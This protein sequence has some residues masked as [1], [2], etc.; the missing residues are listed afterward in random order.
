MTMI[1][2]ITGT[3]IHI[4][5][6]ALVIEAHGI[7]YR[8]FVPQ[9]VVG[10]ACAH[11]T[12]SLWTSFVVR[13]QSQDLYGFPTRDEYQLFE[14]V[15]TVSGIGPKTALGLFDTLPL[16]SLVQ[17]LVNRD[18]AALARTPG[19]GKKGAEKIVLELADKVEGF[20][21]SGSTAP[22]SSH[23]DLADAL[24]SLGYSTGQIRNVLSSIDTTLGLEEQLRVA[25]RELQ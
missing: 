1:N 6:N 10:Q 4:D 19:I 15:I 16:E 23:T 22:Y 13:E 12:I 9:H 2:Y 5:I 20:L 14:K 8:V 17:A 24:A 3:I 18:A 7:G 25:L 11:E 21:S